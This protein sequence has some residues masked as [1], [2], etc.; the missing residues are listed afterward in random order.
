MVG[1]TIGDENDN[2]PEFS[3]VA[4]QKIQVVE[5]TASGDPVGTI[6]ATDKDVGDNI[7]YYMK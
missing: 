4:E 5:N 6:T 7:T 2:S 3:K 1:I